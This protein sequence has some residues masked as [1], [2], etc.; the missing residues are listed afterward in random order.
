MLMFK[1]FDDIGM[2]GSPY[3][4]RQWLG[5]ITDFETYLRNAEWGQS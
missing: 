1:S 3:N 2:D 4:L 5:E